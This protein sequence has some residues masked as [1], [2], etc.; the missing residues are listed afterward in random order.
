MDKRKRREPEV[1][2]SCELQHCQRKVREIIS[3]F[4]SKTKAYFSKYFKGYVQTKFWGFLCLC[5]T[6]H[7]KIK[8]VNSRRFFFCLCF[9]VLF[10]LA[11][12][13]KSI[14]NSLCTGHIRT[15]FLG[16]IAISR[17]IRSFGSFSCIEKIKQVWLGVR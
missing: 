9:M 13:Q 12:T 16:E 8:A 10:S 1:T 14:N 2:S 4:S 3:K 6:D 15:Y 11:L 7:Q 17:E 5:L